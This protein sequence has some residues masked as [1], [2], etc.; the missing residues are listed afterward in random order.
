MSRKI[1]EE[2]IRTELCDGPI[3]DDQFPNTTTPGPDLASNTTSDRIEL[4]ERLKKGESPAWSPKRH[5]RPH[6]CFESVVG[7]VAY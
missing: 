6:H 4:I 7:L 1:S 2:S 5:V 3:P